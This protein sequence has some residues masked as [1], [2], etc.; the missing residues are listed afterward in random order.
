[1]K[2]I[3]LIVLIESK[4]DQQCNSTRSNRHFYTI[5]GHNIDQSI[6]FFI[7]QRKNL[8]YRN[9]PNKHF[10]VSSLKIWGV[11]TF[12]MIRSCIPKMGKRNPF[13]PFFSICTWAYKTPYCFN[14]ICTLNLKFDRFN[15]R[16]ETKLRNTLFNAWYWLF[17]PEPGSWKPGPTL[18]L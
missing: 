10:L 8:I 17:L 3:G 13:N 4:R 15:T 5:L 18:N 2:R 11:S 12:F 9:F 16:Y 6:I 14:K 7:A 1:M